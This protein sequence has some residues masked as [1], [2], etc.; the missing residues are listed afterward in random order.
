MPESDARFAEIVGRHLH[1]HFVTNADADEIFAHFA[2]DMGKD[3]VAVGQ[4]HP[5]HRPGQHLRHGA[6]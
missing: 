1:V 3:L 4:R 2:R 5:K 6:G